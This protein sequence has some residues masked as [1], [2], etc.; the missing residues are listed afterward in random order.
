MGEILEGRGAAPLRRLL[1]QFPPRGGRSRQGHARDVPRPPVRQGRDV[2]FIGPE[3]SLGRARVP[4]RERG[5][6]VRGARRPVSSRRHRRRR[7][8]APAVRKI[9]VEAGSR[10]RTVTGK[11]PPART[12]PTTRQGDSRSGTAAARAPRGRPHAERHRGHGARD[13]RDHGELPGRRRLGRRCRSRSG[14]SA[15]RARS[16]AATASAAERVPRESG[17]H[18]PSGSARLYWVTEPVIHRDEVVGLLFTVNDMSRALQGHPR[19][20]GGGGR[21]RRRG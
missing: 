6:L 18:S 4:A 2:R 11:S 8:G 15:R 19:R 20:P 9:D 10:A 3:E 1:D 21:W 12:R 7:H 16:A 14:S 17:L 13:A 5:G